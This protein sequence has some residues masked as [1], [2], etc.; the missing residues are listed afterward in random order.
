MLRV[1]C[2]ALMNAVPIVAT[3]FGAAYATNRPPTASG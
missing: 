3:V 1:I 2:M